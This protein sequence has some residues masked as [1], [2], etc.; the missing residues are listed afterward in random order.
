MSAAP[1]MLTALRAALANRMQV[2]INI[3]LGA[4]LSTVILT[5]PVI[6]ASAL[7]R[8]QPITMAMTPVQTVLAAITCT[9]TLR[10]AEDAGSRELCRSYDG[11]A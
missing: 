10:T 5:V 1:E 3:A 2:V 7:I 4:S 11:V 9:H 6:E 8:G